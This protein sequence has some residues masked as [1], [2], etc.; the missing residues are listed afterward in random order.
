MK[1]M[2]PRI[3]SALKLI[4]IG[5][6]LINILFISALELKQKSQSYRCHLEHE[7]SQSLTAP[8]D[9]NFSRKKASSP[10]LILHTGHSTKICLI[11]ATDHY[12]SVTNS[13]HLE[14]PHFT[15]PI[16][17]PPVV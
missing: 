9:Q 5:Q 11:S 3:L 1:V 10:E 16:R 17:G 4:L 7:V 14:I 2:K 6:G 8:L 15:Q 12:F 13:S